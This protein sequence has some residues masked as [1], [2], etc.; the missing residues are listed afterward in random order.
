M[1]LDVIYRAIKT[2]A[3]GTSG[4]KAGADSKAI[5]GAEP[6]EHENEENEGIRRKTGT[7]KLDFR[8]GGNECKL[9]EG[10]RTRANART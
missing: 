10:T 2:G 8:R 1:R 4:V 3:G 6:N 7:N 9:R 5:A